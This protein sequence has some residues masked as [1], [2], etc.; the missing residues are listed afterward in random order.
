MKPYYDHAGITIYHGACEE[1]VPSLGRFDLL[2]TDPPYGIGASN[3]SFIGL[4]K[5]RN[6]CAPPKD[7]GDSG[8]DSVP[9]SNETVSLLRSRCEKQIIFGGNYYE[10]PP[11]SC[12]LIWDKEN[13]KNYF[14]DAEMAWTNLKG[15]VRLKRHLW[16]GMLRKGGED[17]FHPTQKPLDVILWSMKLAGD[18]ET[19]LDPFMGSGT[20]LRA[21]KDLGKRCVGIDKEERYCSIAVKR[22]EQ[23]CLPIFST[24]QDSIREAFFE[25]SP[26]LLDGTTCTTPQD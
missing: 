14:A 24:G 6:S 5:R 3:T 2:L 7:Y 17:R 15:A 16:H 21:A 23:E 20:T 12:W 19:V 26:L 13:G 11:T 18:C 25:T 1:I 22:L 9:I 4:K 10:L 8:W